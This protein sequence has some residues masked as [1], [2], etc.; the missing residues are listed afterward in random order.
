MLIEASQRMREYS[1]KTS[2]DDK[3]YLKSSPHS[4]KLNDNNF[5]IDS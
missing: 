4:E 3:N 1:L 2:S 5:I